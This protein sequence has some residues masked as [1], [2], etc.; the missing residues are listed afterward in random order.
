ML[1]IIFRT[2]EK[3]PLQTQFRALR[4]REYCRPVFQIGPAVQVGCSII[5]ATNAPTQVSFANADRPTDPHGSARS[6]CIWKVLILTSF[7]DLGLAAPL[8]QALQTEGYTSPTP[9]QAQAIPAILSGRD[10]LG[11]AQTGTGKTAAFALPMI[12]QLAASKRRP[13]R[14]TCRALILSPTRELASQ[15]A[16]SFRAY[17]R[18]TQLSVSVVYGGVGYGPQIRD[19]NAGLDIL[20]ATPGRLLDHLQRRTLRLD[21]IEIFVLDEADQMLDLGFIHAIRR[22][23]PLL[24]QKDRKSTRLNSSH[25]QKSRMPSSA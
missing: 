8:L 5:R 7:N 15:I 9:I 4:Q 19:L 11:I 24:P 17:G 6:A 2:C 1:D 23:V 14:G 18:N 13:A 25:I 16:E 12:Q 3:A 22:L 21:Q 10:L 20:V